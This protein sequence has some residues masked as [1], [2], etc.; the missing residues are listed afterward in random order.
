VAKRRRAA[1]HDRRHAHPPRL[2][3]DNPAWSALTTKQA[4]IALG[5]RSRRFPVNVTPIGAVERADPDALEE[6][7][8]LTPL[9]DWISLPATVPGLAPLVPKRLR[10]TLEK[11]LVQMVCDRPV[12]SAPLPVVTTQLA[13]ADIPAMMTLTELTHPGPFRTHTYTLGKY[14]GIYE[15]AQ[16]AAMAGQRMHVPGHREISA[17]CTH[18]DFQGRGYAR[19]L[20]ATLVNEILNDGMGVFLHVEESNERAQALYRSLGFSERRRLPLLV[21][22]RVA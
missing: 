9:G 10:V 14:L 16:L 22:A 5:T 12:S 11:L 1:A 19:F 13:E 6:L 15:G 7:A 21:A 8:G 2:V 3:L 4:H 17:V 18:P 20:V